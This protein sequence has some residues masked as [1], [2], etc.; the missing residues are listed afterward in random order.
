M[1]AS[2][3]P[4]TGRRCRLLRPKQKVSFGAT[5]IPAMQRQEPFTTGSFL[6]GKLCDFG[7]RA[8][9]VHGDP[10]STQGGPSYH[11]CQ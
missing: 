6:A 8:T 1:Y 2:L 7:C 11:W 3:D 9:A 10:E 5:R 4:D